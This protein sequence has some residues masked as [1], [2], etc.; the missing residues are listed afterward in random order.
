M[1]ET[2]PNSDQ[3]ELTLFGPGFGECV[4]IHLGDNRWIVV[5]SC[6]DKTTG[7][8]A[9]LDYFNTIGLSPQEVVKLIVIS[10]WHDDHVRGLSKL[11]SSC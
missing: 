9:V 10:H 6:S 2:P 11:V 7:N 1:T 3:I 5:D 8:P 4:A